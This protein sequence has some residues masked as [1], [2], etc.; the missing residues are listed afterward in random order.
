MTP[1]WGVRELERLLPFHP[2]PPATE[3]RSTTLGAARRRSM[4]A[5]GDINEGSAWIDVGLFYEAVGQAPTGLV[6]SPDQ[7]PLAPT[8]DALGLVHK[9]P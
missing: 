4:P 2:I 5:A 6:N 1:G 9:Q 3:S 8:H 7:D